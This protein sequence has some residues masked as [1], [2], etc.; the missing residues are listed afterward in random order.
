MRLGEGTE[1]SESQLPHHIVLD[2]CYIHGDASL[3]GRRGVTANGAHIAVIESYVSNFRL[4]NY[5]TQAFASWNGPGP[6]L[7]RNSYL[8]ASGENVMF[9]GSDAAIANL[10]PSDITIVGNDLVKPL[11]WR[12]RSDAIVKNLFELKN[13]R[14][15]LVDNNRFTNNWADGQTG[16]AIN[17][18]SV[19]QEG[20]NPWAVAEHITITNNVISHAGGGI[21]ISTD[22]GTQ[23]T[24]RILIR[25]NV[26]QDINS[27][28]WGG[29]GQF[30]TLLGPI[31]NITVDGNRVEQDGNIIIADGTP[32]SGFVFVNNIVRHNANGVKGSGRAIGTGTLDYYF[33][34]YVFTGNQIVGGG[35]FAALYPAGNTF[36]A[37]TGTVPS[38]PQGVRI[39]G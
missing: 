7:L 28:A 34:Q 35:P 18:K 9:G 13:A 19:N 14:R 6:F 26:F 38:A 21:V 16:T 1:T 24:G 39:T 11:D 36:P 25:G 33:P 2:R 31:A 23:T 30:L 10:V 8:E 4:G 20:T 15:V 29:A 32:M 3:G 37:P 27:A 12:G 22:S 5:D 17:L